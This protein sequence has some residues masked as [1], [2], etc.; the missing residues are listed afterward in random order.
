MEKVLIEILSSHDIVS[1]RQNSREMARQLG[2]GSADQTRLATAV[3]ELVRNVL[4]YAGAGE[5]LVSDQSDEHMAVIHI[6]VEDHG[7]GIA[8]INKA[9]QSGFTTGGGL[10]AGL[11]GAKR[12]AHNFDISSEPGLTTVSL[13]MSRKKV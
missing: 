4:Q 5:C 10:G 3:S 12:L 2:F 8:N 9:M 11:P 13:V 6:Q 1:A 7:P